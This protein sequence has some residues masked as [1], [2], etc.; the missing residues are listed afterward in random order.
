M[1]N[2]LGTTEK[3]KERPMPVS[4]EVRQ[5][6][7]DSDFGYDYWDNPEYPGH[8][9]YYYD[10][11]WKEPARQ[12]IEHYE[13]NDSSS[14]LD[15]GCGKGYLVH[16]MRE[17]LP[18]MRVAGLDVSSYALEQAKEE[19]RDK[20]IEGSATDLPFADN[21]FDLVVSL[22]TVYMLSEEDCRKAI[23]EIERVSKNALIQVVS[24]R[25]DAERNNML[26]WDI[27]NVRKSVSEW[28]TFYHD[29]HYTGDQSWFIFV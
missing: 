18:T 4:E 11:R 7:R 12:L 24:Y 13:L 27:G 28:Q 5:A 19:I 16:E 23:Q 15:V 9:G 2:V 10:G 29:C 26:S 3:T 25:N 1:L 20:L 17:W 14:F 8:K 22:A 21:E 6:V